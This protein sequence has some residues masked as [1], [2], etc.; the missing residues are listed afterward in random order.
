MLFQILASKTVSSINLFS[1]LN[2][3]LQVF[4]YSKRKQTNRRHQRTPDC[5]LPTCCDMWTLGGC[6]L[7]MT[8][9][10]LLPFSWIVLDVESLLVK[11][12]FARPVVSLSSAQVVE[13]ISP[14][15]LIL[16]RI[17]LVGCVV[18]NVLSCPETPLSSVPFWGG[19]GTQDNAGCPLPFSSPP[20]LSSYSL[21][22]KE[23]S[24][25]W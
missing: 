15:I 14:E 16:S 8:Q 4:C 18:H 22:W 3:Q 1:L 2:A 13:D 9:S 21:P 24:R 23:L 25:M 6:P 12:F 11:G 7:H 5:S 19:K 10:L 17:Y 20:S